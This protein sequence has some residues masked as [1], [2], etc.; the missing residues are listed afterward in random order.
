MDEAQETKLAPVL[1]KKQLQRWQ[2]SLLEVF[3]CLP[4]K[5]GTLSVPIASFTSGMEKTRNCVPLRRTHE[6]RR[7]GFG[8]HN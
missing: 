8:V 3:D 6:R 4:W 1:T 7:P 5:S 2:K